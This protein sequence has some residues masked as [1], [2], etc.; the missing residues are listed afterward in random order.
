MGKPLD[1][2]EKLYEKRLYEKLMQILNDPTYSIRH[3]HDRIPFRSIHL[4]FFQNLF[5]L[6][7]VLAVPDTGSC[8]GLQN[9]TG[10]PA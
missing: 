10:H 8:V 3:Y 6:F 4:H 1:N 2:I 9:K 7:A 5:R